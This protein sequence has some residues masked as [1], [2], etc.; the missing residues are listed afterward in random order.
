MGS[1]TTE[2]IHKAPCSV[3]VAR[4]ARKELPRSIVVGV[5]GSPES[6]AAY[7]AA[8]HVAQRFDAKLWPVVAHGGVDKR[9]TAMIAGDLEDLLD[10]P[11]TALVAA[12]ADADLLVVG[13]RGLHGLSRS[14]RSRSASHTSPLVGTGRPRAGLAADQRGARAMNTMTTARADVPTCRL[15]QRYIERSL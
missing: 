13:S 15:V 12:S 10:K 6:A 3:L 1:T 9:L 2:L 11:V 7:A 5:D 14:D 8:R 4:D